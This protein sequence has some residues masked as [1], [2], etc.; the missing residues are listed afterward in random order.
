MK[1]RAFLLAALLAVPVVQA[2][3]GI[4]EFQVTPK[5]HGEGVLNRVDRGAGVINISHGPVAFAGWDTMTRDLRLKP[6][7]LANGLTPGMRVRFRLQTEDGLHYSVIA[8][9]PVPQR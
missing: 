9:E 3:D 1:R 8:I 5:F 7:T 6:K 2:N 4:L